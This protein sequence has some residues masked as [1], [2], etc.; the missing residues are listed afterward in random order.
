V[1]EAKVHVTDVREDFLACL[2]AYLTGGEVN[3]V[4]ALLDRSILADG[5][6]IVFEE[7][8]AIVEFRLFGVGGTEKQPE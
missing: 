1:A 4:H 7:H 6:E 5:L 3:K 2:G 8:K